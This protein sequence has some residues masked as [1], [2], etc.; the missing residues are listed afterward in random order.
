[1]YVANILFMSS[2]ARHRSRFENVIKMRFENMLL[3]VL[4]S[5]GEVLIDCYGDYMIPVRG[6]SAHTM[7]VFDTGKSY[8][9]YIRN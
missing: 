9:E 1:M 7:I 6:S 2:S 4:E 8:L 3:P 5:Y